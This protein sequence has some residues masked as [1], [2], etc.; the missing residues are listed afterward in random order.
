MWAAVWTAM[1]TTRVGVIGAGMVDVC[2]ASWLRRDGHDVFVVEA[3]EP[4]N[5]ASCGNAGA[6]NGSSRYLDLDARNAPARATLAPRLGSLSVRWF[7]LPALAP[8]LVRFVHAGTLEKVHAQARALPPLV[9]ATLETLVPLV[10]EAGAPP[11]SF[12]STGIFMSIV[13]R[14]A[15]KRIALPGSFGEKMG[16][17]W[18]RSTVMNCASSNQFCPPSTS[19][20]CWS[21]KMATPSFDDQGPRIY[22]AHPDGDA[23]GK[24]VAM[25]METGLRFAGTVELAG[26]RASPDWRRARILLEQG[27]RMLLST[28]LSA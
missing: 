15:S 19:A 27:R 13:L 9:G 20:E 4:G 10:R 28:P 24:F 26:V 7:Y 11:T 25:P 21:A 5:G 6:F 3:D 12:T 17:S 18:M 23:K 1:A 8:W 2:V 16:L 14:K 22:A